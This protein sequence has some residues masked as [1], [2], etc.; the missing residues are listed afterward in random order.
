MYQPKYTRESGETRNIR[1]IL[2]AA[3]LVFRWDRLGIGVVCA[4]LSVLIFNILL[5]LGS[6]PIGLA[7]LMLISGILSVLIGQFGSA[8]IARSVKLELE[9]GR[10]LTLG[11]GMKFLQRNITSLALYILLLVGLILAALVGGAILSSIGLIPAVGP[12]LYG[13]LISPI[14]L[15]TGV[16]IV[17]T[18]LFLMISSFIFPAHVAVEETP[19]I[20]TV[21]HMI[22]LVRHRG[23]FIFGCQMLSSIVGLGLS[24]LVNLV[25]FGGLILSVGLG[26][27]LMQEKFGQLM[28][29]VVDGTWGGGALALLPRDLLEMTAAFARSNVGGSYEI[30]GF[31]W[32]FGLLSSSFPVARFSGPI[33]RLG[34]R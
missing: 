25:F 1:Y 33:C 24:L 30:G 4:I 2:Q 31:F 32:G 22:D 11:E 9:E 23:F 21:K 19:L 7:I 8:L 6:R 5:A 20:E 12:V 10:R 29:G 34:E 28:I 16:A 14:S 27:V 3:G 18:V 26:A 15:I 13:M 17:V